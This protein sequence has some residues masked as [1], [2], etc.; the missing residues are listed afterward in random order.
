MG[1][2]TGHQIEAVREFNRFYT[3]QI[4][5][6]NRE[7][8]G[9]PFSL[10]EVRVLLELYYRESTTASAIG[11][12]LGLDAGYLSRILGGFSR[13]GL[14]AKSAPAPDGRQK[15]HTLSRAG[16]K[17]FEQLEA[18]Q[19]QAV[20]SFLEPNSS[21]QRVQLV[22]AMRKIERIL[23]ASLKDRAEYLL[24][25][26]RPGDIGWVIHRQAIIYNEEYGWDESYEAL[27][28]EILARFV[29]NFDPKRERS[30]IAERD[31]EIVG[32]IFCVSKS[33]TV[34]RLRLLYVEPTARGLGIGTRLV[35][36]CILF[37]RRAG[38]RKLTL[39]TNSV[40][41]SARRI[42]EGK[43]FRLVKEERHRSFGKNLVGQNWELDLRIS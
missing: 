26:P 10:A 8:L 17:E 31:G 18:R 6:L 35:D 33:K 29:Q 20:A 39:W 7:F 16:R 23:G 28:A 27:V 19:R 37:A 2:L 41:E 14:L 1:E 15:R 38:Y 40:L 3:K 5:V 13:R 24:R 21:D 11:Q 34:A 22:G 25:P 43:G 9:S 12:D 4:G 32:S 30:W 42:Y 36:E